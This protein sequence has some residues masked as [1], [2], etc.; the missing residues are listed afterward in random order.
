M[1]LG[2]YAISNAITY[3]SGSLSNYSG[4][5]GTLT[6]AADLGLTNDFTAS[7]VL[8]AG[9]TLTLSGAYAAA[10]APTFTLDSLTGTGT[11]LFD[12][13]NLDA[14]GGGEYVIAHADN[15]SSWT[16]TSFSYDLANAASLTRAYEF[17]T[18]ADGDLVLTLSAAGYYWRLGGGTADGTWDVNASPNWS[19]TATGTA[20]SVFADENMAFFVGDGSNSTI[21]TVAAGVTAGDGSS[22]GAG[23]LVVQ[24]GSYSFV[25]DALTLKGSLVVGNASDSSESAQASFATAPT[26]GGST[27]VY[28]AGSSLTIKAGGLST[29]NL[30]NAGTVSVEAG[31]VSVTNAVGSNGGTLHIAAGG[32]SLGAGS[33]SFAEL[34]VS[35]GITGNSGTLTVGGASSAASVSG[36]GA[37][38]VSSGGSMHIS[39]ASSTQLSQLSGAGSLITAAGLSLQNNSSIGSLTVGSGTLTLA[40]SLALTGNLSASSIAITSLQVATPAITATG[41][42]IAASGADF[43]IAGS[44]LAS[45]GLNDA[46][47]SY[48]LADLGAAYGGALTLNGSSQ[49]S[50]G[51]NLFTISSQGDDIVITRSFIPSKNYYAENIHQTHNGLAGA[52]LVDGAIN[53]FDPQGNS[54][55]YPDI[56]KVIEALND[57]LAAGNIAGADRL[58]AAVAGASITTLGAAFVSDVERQLKMVRNRCMS[59][60]ADPH[61]VNDFPQVFGWISAHGSSSKLSAQNTSAGYTLNNW[62][63][64]FGADVNINDA[65]TL[66]GAITAMYGKLNTSAPDEASGH[67][68]TYYLTLLGR[69]MK[70][71]WAHSFVLTAG[72]AK[73]KLDRRV[74]LGADSYATS[75][76]TDGF[77]LGFMYE[78]GY[79]IAMNDEASTCWQP[80]FNAALIHTQLK[81]YDEGG[82]D[83][84]LR[85]DHMRNASAT[86]GAGARLERI[87]VF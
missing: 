24:N 44:T 59:M 83:A 13:S 67:L 20:D 6:V 38:A 32:L 42:L 14:L 68:D 80:V 78:L 15:L 84:A 58:A 27:F 75:G 33:N 71:Q 30:S 19:T 9:D 10:T 41:S 64:N 57:E 45:L 4:Y 25:G 76:S 65:L 86:L 53:G 8:E 56:N 2:N 36:N 61:V 62:G 12:V 22:L 7:A 18:N 66:G 79:T 39:G 72:L 60:G 47:P 28:G 5:T 81:G 55:L 3:N 77:G 46:N 1:D 73:A 70:G 26:I 40:G 35:G 63:G 34:Q 87:V 52:T 43:E 50:Y 48:T 82:S 29:T 54:A 17:S 85:A 11:L 51:Q 16:G 49:Y 21:I 69:Y 74:I 31:D 37:L 23:V